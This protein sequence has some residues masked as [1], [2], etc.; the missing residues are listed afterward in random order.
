MNGWQIARQI[1]YLLRARRWE[2]G[3]AVD[4]YEH[5]FQSS[6]VRVTPIAS[7]DLI[8][9]KAMPLCL[10]NA[11]NEQADPF[12]GQEP[13]FVKQDFEVTI[14]ALQP[15]EEAGENAIIGGGRAATNKS[16]RGR[17][18]LEVEEEVKEVLNSVFAS[19]GIEMQGFWSSGIAVSL[20]EGLGYV[21]QITMTFSIFGTSFRTYKG[22]S[23]FVGSGATG[24]TISMTW[25][26]AP[27]RWDRVTASGGQR[28]RY[29]AGAVAPTTYSSGT[30]GPTIT[31]TATSSSITGLSSGTYSIS[32]FSGY[33]EVG[34]TTPDRWSDP[35]SQLSITVP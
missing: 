6:S 23:A 8:S 14:V 29:A 32:I 17:G 28:I 10:I 30:A 25:A 13:R 20:V 11:G 18:V 31:G 3:A 24:G 5:V 21:A 26:A 12:A 2:G 33:N 4:G 1:R 15:G 27:D 34:G 35:V 22:V 7:G 16:S 9:Q 19:S